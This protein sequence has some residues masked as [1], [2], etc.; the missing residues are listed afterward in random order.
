M[1]GGDSSRTRT[2]LDMASVDSTLCNDLP[3]LI[4]QSYRHL[5]AISEAQRRQTCTHSTRSSA[6][7]DSS[8]FN[9]LCSSCRQRHSQNGKQT[10]NCATL[11]SADCKRNG[12][13]H[14][15][16]GPV[17]DNALATDDLLLQIMQKALECSSE[18][19]E[20]RSS[21][22]SPVVSCNNTDAI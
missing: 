20:T 17:S 9:I 4:A 11:N 1:T 3:K 21:K 5:E 15:S 14:S 6:P 10:L 13:P 8:S 12:L 16:F 18:S 7:G 2:T 19:D 22:V